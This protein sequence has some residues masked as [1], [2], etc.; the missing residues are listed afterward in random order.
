[1]NG[2][3]DVQR[4]W[5][6]ARAPTRETN[7]LFRQILVLAPRLSVRGSLTSLGP[8]TRAGSVC[9]A[10]SRCR[11]GCR[12]SLVSVVHSSAQ[13]CF[14]HPICGHLLQRSRKIKQSRRPASNLHL[15]RFGEADP[16]DRSAAVVATVPNDAYSDALAPAA[17]PRWTADWALHSRSVPVLWP[18][19]A[20]TVRSSLPTRKL[21][22][23]RRPCGKIQNRL[24]PMV[25]M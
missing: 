25:R 14:L 6:S 19:I 1:M 22:P 8:P 12:Q 9:R 23:N 17:I 24:P 15:G 7:P 5:H 4:R 3:E 10:L 13:E 16:H 20:S 2:S 21:P 18:G 11:L